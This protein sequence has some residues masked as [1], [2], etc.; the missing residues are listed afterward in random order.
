MNDQ[1]TIRTDLR[2]GD[3]GRIVTLHGEGY[4]REQ[5][6]FGL[7]FEAFVSRT[8]A[9][10]VLTDECSGRV[11]LAELEDKLV[12]CIAMVDRGD[13]GQLRWVIV[14]PEVRGSGLGK[15]LIALAMEYAQ[16][17]PWREIFLETTDGLDASMAIYRNL[18][19]E[20]VDRTDEKLWNSDSE[21]KIV[22]T[23]KMA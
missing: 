20:I 19:F 18:G 7:K 5:S 12:G 1:I 17:M 2:P 10:F 15:R 13:K 21:T 8:L 14:S 22:M 3:L 16:E 6:H 9:D 11:W 4:E 23:K